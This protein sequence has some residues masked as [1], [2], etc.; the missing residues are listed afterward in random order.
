MSYKIPPQAFKA[1]APGASDDSTKGYV[2]GSAII[3]TST[4]P[5]KVYICSNATAGAAAWVDAGGVTA[6]PALSTLGWSSAGHT[7]VTN[8]VACFDETTGAAKTVQATQEGSVLA[9]IGGVLTFTTM[10]ATVGILAN[11]DRTLETEYLLYSLVTT[12]S[13]LVSPGTIA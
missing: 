11:L 13:T 3:D 10:A 6:H 12:P 9:L 1:G 7:G 8:S 4:T 5:R 2:V